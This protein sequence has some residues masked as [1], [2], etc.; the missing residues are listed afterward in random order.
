MGEAKSTARSATTPDLAAWE[1]KRREAVARAIC[2]ACEENPDHRGDA[3]GNDFRWQDY[4]ETA[5]AAITAFLQSSAGGPVPAVG[6]L[7]TDE[8]GGPYMLFFDREEAA[9]Y[10]E[11][12]EDPIPL[13][14]LADA[15]K[16]RGANDGH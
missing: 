5:D 12:D 15:L 4:L 1:A 14:Y 9:G 2:A 13:G 6:W 11:C 3:Q 16:D 10:C 8:D 7:T